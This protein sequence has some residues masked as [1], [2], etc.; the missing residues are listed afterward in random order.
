MAFDAD[1]FQYAGRTSGT[2]RV[3]HQS[4]VFRTKPYPAIRKAGFDR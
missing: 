1:A 4:S 2:N 3:P